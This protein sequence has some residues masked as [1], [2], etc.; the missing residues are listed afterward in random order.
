MQEGKKP[1]PEVRKAEPDMT[2]SFLRPMP[3][4]DRMY[5]ETDIPLITPELEGIKKSELIDEKIASLEQKYRLSADLAK[6][7]IKSGSINFEEYVQEFHQV[8]PSFIAHSLISIP[9]ELKARFNID[10]SK[11][12]HSDIKEALNFL[13]KGDISKEAVLELLVAVAKGLP[14][15]ISKYKK[16][17]TSG[18]ESEIKVLITQKPGLNIGAYMGILMAKYRGKVD[19]RELMDVLKKYVN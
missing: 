7:I 4:A 12:S 9:K 3:G 1:A 16:A 14:M 15:D 10:P 19:G 13:N 11:I 8:E 5:P 6:A 2:T 18:I 17:D